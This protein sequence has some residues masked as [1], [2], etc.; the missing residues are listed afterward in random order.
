[1]SDVA[2]ILAAVILT[3]GKLATCGA[4]GAA[5]SSLLIPGRVRESGL[6]LSGYFLGER[7]ENRGWFW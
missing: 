2:F 4:S 7:G 1:M 6:A 3:E 5:I